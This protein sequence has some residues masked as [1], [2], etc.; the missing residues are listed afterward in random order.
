[1]RRNEKLPRN[2]EQKVE[3]K[4]RSLENAENITVDKVSDSQMF[5]AL[6]LYGV[7]QT[8]FQVEKH[9]GELKCINGDISVPVDEDQ[10]E[11]ESEIREFAVGNPDRCGVQSRIEGDDRM[12][13]ISYKNRD[14]ERFINALER[15]D[16]E[17]RKEFL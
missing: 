11:V 5:V 12:C 4:V 1:M 10:E 13:V 7:K 15:F 14:Y 8:S 2:I 3:N 6:H 9:R 17:Y 16:Q